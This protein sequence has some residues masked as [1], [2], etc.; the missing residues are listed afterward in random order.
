MP[1]NYKLYIDMFSNG[2]VKNNKATVAKFEFNDKYGVESSCMS[3]YAR[4]LGISGNLL[5]CVTW[6]R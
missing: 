4:C 2:S 6:L 1:S 3:A 5:F